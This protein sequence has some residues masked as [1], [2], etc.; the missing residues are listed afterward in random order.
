MFISCTALFYDVS[1]LFVVQG[2]LPNFEGTTNLTHVDLSRNRSVAL[3]IQ[4]CLR[5]LT[6]IN[7]LRWCFY[8]VFVRQVPWNDSVILG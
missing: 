8:L 3:V 6:A 4:C 7:L 2:L 5:Y 1:L